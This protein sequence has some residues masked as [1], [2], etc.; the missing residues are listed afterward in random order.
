[1]RFSGAHLIGSNIWVAFMKTQVRRSM[2]ASKALFQDSKPQ[3]LVVLHYFAQSPF[4]DQT[5]NNASIATQAIYNPAMA[6]ILETRDSFEQSLRSLSGL[7]FMVV[8]GPKDFGGEAPIGEGQWVIR[9]QTRRKRAG[10]DDEL[11]ILADY[12]VIGENVY[13]APSINNIL[14]SKLV[15]MS[16]PLPKLW[17]KISCAS[18]P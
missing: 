1:M 4:F 8:L 10:G 14:G 6:Y 9:K 3:L 13:M 7:E 5:S 16:L 12:F 2:L 18:S 17:L 15:G 11:T